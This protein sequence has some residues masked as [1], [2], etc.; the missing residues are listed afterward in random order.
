MRL[1][2]L[3][4]TLVSAQKPQP[5]IP[6]VVVTPDPEYPETFI[7]STDAS[8]AA[9]RSLMFILQAPN[10]CLETHADLPKSVSK[11]M[12]ALWIRAGTLTLN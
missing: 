11:N 5:N 1:G 2:I 8:Q 4:A 3:L 9:V 10:N 7:G 6:V 12:A